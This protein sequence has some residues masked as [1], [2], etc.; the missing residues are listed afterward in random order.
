MTQDMARSRVTAGTPGTIAGVVAQLVALER[1]GG[2]GVLKLGRGSELKV[3]SLAKRYFDGGA[4]KGALMRYYANMWPALKAHVVDR[5]LVLKRY[6]EGAG[7][8][9]FFQQNAGEHVPEAVRVEAIDT[10]GDG[11][12][13]RIIG[14]DLATLLYTVQIGAIEVHPWLS[15]VGDIDA[16][17]RCLIDL[18]PGPD[19]PFR[20]VVALT[21]AVLGV[22]HRCALPAAVKTSGSSGMHIVIPLPRATSYETSAALAMLI[23]RVVTVQNPERATVERSLRARPPGTIYVDAMQNARGKSMACA[24][25]VRARD[26]A[27]VS[28]PLEER[29]LTARLRTE[30]HSLQ[31][32]PRR[33]ARVG[34]LW[35]NALAARTGKK[36]LV[37]AMKLLTEMLDG[38]E[39]TSALRRG[40]KRGVQGGAD[41]ESRAGR[42]RSRRS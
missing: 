37:N 36:V 3:S 17:D 39:E 25:S 8:P 10:R 24:Y 13:D 9:M 20:G 30:A 41:V 18:D 32:M 38:A 28:A 34:D 19:V 2:A 6:P 23:A 31:S 12:K 35:G 15:K 11:P 42:P 33:V 7:G 22:L 5:P 26:G 40:K 16:A 1:S 21:R 4:T 14:G 29:E 27:P